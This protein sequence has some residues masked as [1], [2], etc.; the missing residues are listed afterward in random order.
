MQRDM[1]HLYPTNVSESEARMFNQNYNWTV[2]NVL[3]WS[4]MILLILLFEHVIAAAR[5]AY[6]H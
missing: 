5:A 6:L 3:F 2:Q 4:K 1:L